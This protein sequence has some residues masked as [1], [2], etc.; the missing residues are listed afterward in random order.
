MYLPITI[1]LLVLLTES[2]LFLGFSYITELAYDTFTKITKDAQVTKQKKLKTDILKLKTE[3]SQT[4]S[5][6]EFAKWAKLR[7]KLDKGMADL[8]KL[9]SDI[10]YSK[11]AFE[12][13][14]KSVLWFL[15][16]GTQFIMIFWFRKSAVFYLPPGWFGPAQRFLSW[17]FAP[18]GSV[19]VAV[20]FAACRRM[21]KAVALTMNDFV[22]V[23]AAKEK[24][25]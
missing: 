8:E 7:R 9:N 21:I 17:P 12:L 19:S 22:F 5:Q 13:K 20:W 11:A 16:H 18:A 14:S 3:L 4:S 23:R 2:I 15:V 10:A 1:F 6:D 25:T 24:T